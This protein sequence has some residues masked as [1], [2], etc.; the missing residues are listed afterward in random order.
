MV[1]CYDALGVALATCPAAIPVDFAVI[2][3]GTAL[4]VTVVTVPVSVP[5]TTCATLDTTVQAADLLSQAVHTTPGTALQVK[6]CD[7][8]VNM[9]LEFSETLLYSA[10]TEQTLVRVREYNEDSGAWVLRYENLDGSAYGGVIPP[11]ATATSAQIQVVRTLAAGCAA[12]VPYSQ[13]DTSRFDS[14]TGAL[15]SSVIDW[16]DSTGVAVAIIPSGFTLGACLASSASATFERLCDVSTGGV[17][18]EFVRRVVTT[19]NTLNVPTSTTTDLGLDYVTAYTPNG[20]V[21]ACGQDCDTITPVGLVATW[22]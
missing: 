3:G 18:T 2:S 22:A 17:V 19:F 1:T 13:R 20:T 6:L 8:V 7:P 4:P 21:G 9:K 11:D 14:E 15:E 12:S 10:S 5:A 16:V